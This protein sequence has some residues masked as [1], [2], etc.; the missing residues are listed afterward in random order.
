MYLYVQK[1]DSLNVYL[2]L[3]GEKGC[4]NEDCGGCNEGVDRQRWVGM[5]KVF[6]LVILQA[7][8]SLGRD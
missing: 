3:L 5:G 1:W 2:K 4:E 6:Q 7:L 8:Y